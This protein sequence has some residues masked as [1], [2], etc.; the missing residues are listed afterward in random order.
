MKTTIKCTCQKNQIKTTIN[1]Y[2]EAVHTVQAMGPKNKILDPDGKN[3]TKS[4]I[5]LCDTKIKTAINHLFKNKN[6]INPGSTAKSKSNNQPTFVSKPDVRCHFPR[7]Y[8]ASQQK[9]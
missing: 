3:N 1:L 7:L 8:P 6:T 4:T 2:N 9:N 5:N